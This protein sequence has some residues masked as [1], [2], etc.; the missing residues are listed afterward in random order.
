[1]DAVHQGTNTIRCIQLSGI[2]SIFVLHA[3]VAQEDPMLG[4]LDDV[5]DSRISS[6]HSSKN[7][8]PLLH[9]ESYKTAL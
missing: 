6:V 1:M 7:T 2:Q 5:L 9:F 8:P 4:E 3:S